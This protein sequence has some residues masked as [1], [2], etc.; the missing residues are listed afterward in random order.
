M[1]Y[2]RIIDENGLF[3]K[4]DFVEELTDLTIETP[5]EGGFYK[6]KWDGEKWVEGLTTDEINA[7]KN[8][9]QPKTEMELLQD[10]IAD[11]I[12]QV[13]YTQMLLVDN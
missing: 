11:L 12:S 1:Y 3:I 5:C 13:L 8:V 9:A 10:K 7:I 4:D 6:P 2:V